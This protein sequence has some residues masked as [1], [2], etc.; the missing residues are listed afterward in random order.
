MRMA[1]AA[2]AATLALAGVAYAQDNSGGG[3]LN[4]TAEQIA[5]APPSSC[6]A[7]PSPPEL[8][9]GARARA[10]QVQTA[11]TAIQA[12]DAQFRQVFNCRI[13]ED[14]QL[15]QQLLEVQARRL[16][17]RN[18][19]NA[20]RAQFLETCRAWFTE[21]NEFNERNGQRVTDA[22]RD[23]DARCVGGNQQPQ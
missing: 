3:T 2:A 10:E 9:N 7:F 18:E 11:N 15:E 4:P 14:R 13:A 21:V 16:A 20:G 5:A 22:D 8:P 23:V 19:F 6:D 12:W 1:L 17:R